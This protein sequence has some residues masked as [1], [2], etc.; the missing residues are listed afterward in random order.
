MHMFVVKAVMDF[1]LTIYTICRDPLTYSF[2]HKF[3]PQ[4]QLHAPLVILYA[5]LGTNECKLFHSIMSALAL[6]G[7]VR[8]IFRHFVKV[9]AK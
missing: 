4:W 9:R 2:D 1:D 5:E 8:Y 3:L 7:Q 6:Q